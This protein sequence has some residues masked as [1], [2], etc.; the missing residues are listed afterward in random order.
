MNAN[1]VFLRRQR[2]TKATTAWCIDEPVGRVIAW[3]CD[4]WTRFPVTRTT[5]LSIQQWN[6]WDMR[7]NVTACSVYGI[8]LN[9]RC[10]K[11]MK[12]VPISPKRG[13]SN[14][15]NTGRYESKCYKKN[16]RHDSGT[17]NSFWT[18]PPTDVPEDV[19]ARCHK[20]KLSLMCT[21]FGT[22][23]INFFLL[24]KYD[25]VQWFVTVFCWRFE[26]TYIL[27]DKIWT[28]CLKMELCVEMYG[29]GHKFVQATASQRPFSSSPHPDWPRGFLGYS[30]SNT[31]HV[32]ARVKEWHSLLV[33]LSKRPQQVLVQRGDCT[34]CDEVP[35]EV[36]GIFFDHY[37]ETDQMIVRKIRVFGRRF[38]DCVAKEFD[39]IA[40]PSHGWLRLTCALGSLWLCDLRTCVGVGKN[41]RVWDRTCCIVW[42][43]ESITRLTHSF[44]HYRFTRWFF[45][46]DD[47]PSR[48]Y[49]IE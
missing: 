5:W 17:Y 48:A 33:T 19:S 14:S 45:G 31:Q 24:D 46:R 1:L 27:S 10:L 15:N 43:S 2:T 7:V 44:D 47:F 36:V 16:R 21:T 42:C 22:I 18:I 32:E 40:D 9:A 8:A 37:P 20:F 41:V 4:V 11:R 3:H 23:L 28:A 13:G 26:K 12:S 35:V 29:G 38:G 30:I 39:F 6:I 34:S 25:H 49:V